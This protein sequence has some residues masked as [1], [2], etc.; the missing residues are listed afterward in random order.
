MRR[1][2]QW[3]LAIAVLFFL[4][5][6]ICSA[7]LIAY[8]TKSANRGRVLV[9]EEDGT[10]P[11]E[12]FVGGKF[13][14]L[15][16]FPSVSPAGL[17]ESWVLFSDGYDL[18]KIPSEGGERTLVLCGAGEDKYGQ[19]YFLGLF[20][21]SWLPDG[22]E[23][24]VT[25]SEDMYSDGGTFLAVIPA[26]HTAVQAEICT[27]ELVRIYEP[28]S[29]WSVDGPPAWNRDGSQ[30]A[31]LE[32]NMV[33]EEQ[34]LVVIE[35]QLSG[36]WQPIGEPIELIPGS[37]D[38]PDSQPLF[39]S[40]QPQAESRLLI[41]RL[42][43][44]ADRRPPF[45]LASLD[46]DTGVWDYVLDGGSPLQM[47][48]SSTPRWSSNGEEILYTDPDGDLVI[49]NYLDG[50][51]RTVGSGSWAH[52]QRDVVAGYCGDGD[53]AGSENQCNC[54]EDC[55]AFPS[56]ET[57]LCSDLAD[58]DCDGPVDCADFDCSS[59]AA[60]IDPF[61]GDGTC[62][63]DETQCGCPDDCGS[64]PFNET[65]CTDSVDND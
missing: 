25:P 9:M 6:T 28:P 33:T 8:T 61:C 40:W 5:V 23:I 14:P 34:Q 15:F 56:T 12:L 22:T 3:L 64:A 53:C 45:W 30:I 11:V 57:D 19:S 4:G 55:G 36:A 38:L 58:N 31:F 26:D 43:G 65:S 1:V 49:W 41:F 17:G 44:S 42:R 47:D 24:L 2:S 39:L 20:G 7:N 46:L 52:W 59:D 29:P 32:T 63:P 54:A 48:V 35:R 62:D 27:S 37:P 16:E 21:A 13:S 60:C 51:R 10:N 18:Y 50:S